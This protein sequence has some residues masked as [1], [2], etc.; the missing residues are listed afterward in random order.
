MDKLRWLFRRRVIIGTL[1][2][3]GAIVL[4][5]TVFGRDTSL[6]RSIAESLLLLAGTIIS[7]YVLGATWDDKNREHKTN[8]NNDTK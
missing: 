6:H 3:V 1:I 5:L 8:S 7:T 4:Y 2:Y